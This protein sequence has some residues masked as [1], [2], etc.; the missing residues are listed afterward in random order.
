MLVL[1]LLGVSL[2]LGVVGG[3]TW[4]LVEDWYDRRPVETPAPKEEQKQ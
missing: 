3:V 4:R 2:V 1:A